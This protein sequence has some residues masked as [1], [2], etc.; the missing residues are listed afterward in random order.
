M[1]RKSWQKPAMLA[2]IASA[3]VAIPAL[4]AM[5]KISRAVP[6]PSQTDSGTMVLRIDDYF[7][8]WSAAKAMLEDG[9]IYSTQHG[10]NYIYPPLMAWLFQPLA[11]LDQRPGI[12]IWVVLDAIILLSGLVVFTHELVKRL[13]GGADWSIV[14]GATAIALALLFDKVG[15]Q[16][17]L[18]QTDGIMLLAMGLALR[19]MDS[20]PVLAGIILG[21]AG[22]VK[23]LSLI[24]LPWFI[25][26]RRW[27]A[28]AST[29]IA[30]T[31]GLFIPAI[32]RGWDRNLTDLK[33]A[34]AGL[35]E[36]FGV[37]VDHLP[38]ASSHA[39]TWERSV[40]IT[41]TMFR[42]AESM[43]LGPGVAI[44]LTACIAGICVAIVWVAYRRI[45]LQ[46][47]NIPSALQGVIALEWVGLLVASLTFG[48]QTTARHMIQLAPLFVLAAVAIPIVDPRWKRLIIVSSIILALCLVLPPGGKQFESTLTIWR[49]VGVVSWVSLGLYFLLFVVTLPRATSSSP[50]R[51]NAAS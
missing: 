35:V 25:V 37:N 42:L 40:S 12:Y 5:V 38:R 36:A 17:K 3:L 14:W 6:E 11:M 32:T 34:F 22:N 8:F 47:L 24:A 41:S 26:R 30:F 48:P 18:Q 51:S 13:R 29:V 7:H 15:A 10:Q 27:K 46:F 50:Q 49:A 33:V 23:Y 44:G 20:K 2:V 43:S 19:W 9:D 21:I 31:A 39:I 28:A 4:M 1:Q 16:F 45:Q